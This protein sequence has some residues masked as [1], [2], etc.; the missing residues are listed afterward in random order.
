MR[1]LPKR[2]IAF[3]HVRPAGRGT[4]STH[5]GAMLDEAAGDVSSRA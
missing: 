4:G 5:E 1:M 2:L 3:T